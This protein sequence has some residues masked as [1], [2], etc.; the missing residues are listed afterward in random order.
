MSQMKG[1]TTGYGYNGRSFTMI[2]GYVDRLPAGAYDVN[3]DMVR[4][5]HF[6][7]NELK[8]DE[9]AFDGNS[10]AD[11][12]MGEFGQ[13]MSLRDKYRQY[14]F[15]HKRSFLLYGPPGNGKT[16]ILI[17]LA[18]LLARRHDGITLMLPNRSDPDNVADAIRQLHGLEPARPIVVAMEEVDSLY[19]YFPTE[20]LTLLD[21]GADVENVFFVATTNFIEKLD[22]RVRNRPS[23]FDTLIEVGAP[24]EEVRRAYLIRKGVGL[25][26]AGLIAAASAGL[27]FAHLKEFIIA[28]VILGQP[29]AEVAGRLAQMASVV[30]DTEDADD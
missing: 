18:R 4:N 27:S 22:A 30:A 21:G 23:R 29:I 13:F 16:S 8:T 19:R 26:T 1:P 20:M 7:P 14:G 12:I 3:V 11:R 2:G 24:S 9:L 17:E 10:I 6:S 28:H 25:E 15:V 5:I